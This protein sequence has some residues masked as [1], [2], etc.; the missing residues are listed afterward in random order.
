MLFLTLIPFLVGVALMFPLLSKAWGPRSEPSKPRP[1]TSPLYGR[2]NEEQDGEAQ[3][4]RTSS[5]KL[6]YE[7]RYREADGVLLHHRIFISEPFFLDSS[8]F[9]V[10]NPFDKTGEK[11]TENFTDELCDVDDE[12]CNGC[13]IPEEYKKIAAENTIDVVSFLGLRRAEPLRF[14]CDWE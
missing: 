8:A 2:F 1:L 11:F 10:V 6:H 12:D 4:S 7:S 13:P 5:F 14:P 9:G 3:V